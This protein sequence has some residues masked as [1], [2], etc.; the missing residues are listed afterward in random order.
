MAV[1]KYVPFTP[2]AAPGNWLGIMLLVSPRL[3]ARYGNSIRTLAL[4]RSA[5]MY[6]MLC[7]ALNRL[8]KR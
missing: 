7:F 4:P 3:L 6:E 1:S 8:S 5:S 2:V